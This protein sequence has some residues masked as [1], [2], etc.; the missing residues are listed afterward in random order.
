MWLEQIGTAVAACL[1]LAATSAGGNG[2]ALQ[3]AS[4]VGSG[5]LQANGSDPAIPAILRGTF[6]MNSNNVASSLGFV[7]TARNA[8]TP[9]F[10]TFWGTDGVGVAQ[11]YYRIL[12]PVSAALNF[13]NT[14][15]QTST[16]LT[17]AVPGARDGDQVTVGVPVG[18]I[19]ANSMYWGFVS[20]NDVVTVRFCNF[21]AAAIDPAAG[22]FKVG[23]TRLLP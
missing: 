23:V 7:T 3:M 15:A 9:G 8:P 19:V 1:V 18:S 5:R 12:A 22:T 21:S 20:A 13:G 11:E 4:D 17:V 14:L 2:A 16:D 10:F 6:S